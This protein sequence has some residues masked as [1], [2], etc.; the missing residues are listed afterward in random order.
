MAGLLYDHRLTRYLSLIRGTCP[1]SR[2]LTTL[3]S[4][5]LSRVNP[6]DPPTYAVEYDDG[7]REDRVPS[8]LIVVESNRVIVAAGDGD[9]RRLTKLLKA[10]ARR[11][12]ADSDVN[13]ADRGGRSPLHHAATKVIS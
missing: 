6:G 5:S 9:V 13:V 2:F 11:G 12:T 7:D 10:S 8:H 1:P 3:V 4:S